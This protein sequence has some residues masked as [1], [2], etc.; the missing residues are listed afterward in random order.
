M[1]TVKVHH[2]V[3]GEKSSFTVFSKP[4]GQLQYYCAE[5][6]DLDGS[7]IVTRDE[8]LAM[9]VAFAELA[10]AIQ[11][12]EGI[13]KLVKTDS[14]LDGCCSCHMGF[15][16]CQFCIHTYQCEQ[17]EN[18]VESDEQPDSAVQQ[19]LCGDCYAEQKEQ[20][21]QPAPD[22]SKKVLVEFCPECGCEE[23]RNESGSYRECV[24]CQQDWHLDVDY[25]RAI[26]A[27]LSSWYELKN[28]KPKNT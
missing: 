9:S 24:R 21:N 15:P 13:A 28:D 17:C 12:A 4:I 20:Y 27:N 25:T 5:T 8:A 18:R 16:P 22:S 3:P 11:G 1:N 23:T 7:I 14:R 10:A 19:L 6:G 26:K 2:P